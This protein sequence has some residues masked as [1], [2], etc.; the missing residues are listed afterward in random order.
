MSHV[1]PGYVSRNFTCPSVCVRTETLDQTG[2]VG[3]ESVDVKRQVSCQECRSSS[4]RC[5]NIL[6]SPPSSAVTEVSADPD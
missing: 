5:S 2:L 4:W 3:R 6:F 1:I